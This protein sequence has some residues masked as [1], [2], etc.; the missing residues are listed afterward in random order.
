MSTS[1]SQSRDETGDAGESRHFGLQQPVALAVGREVAFGERILLDEQIVRQPSPA[2]GGAVPLVAVHA[3]DV[4]ETFAVFRFVCPFVAE[5]QYG[6]DA[7]GLKTLQRPSS[8][9]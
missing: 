2:A 7:R 8:V 1:S 3:E 4:H 6:A 9:S 5:R